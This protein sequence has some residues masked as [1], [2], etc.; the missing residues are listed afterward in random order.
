MQAF[1][2]CFNLLDFFAKI[3]SHSALTMNT[4]K[5]NKTKVVSINGRISKKYIQYNSRLRL[6]I[7]EHELKIVALAASYR[8]RLNSTKIMN[9]KTV[10]NEFVVLKGATRV[11]D[12]AHA[13][14]LIHWVWKSERFI[15]I[16][17]SHSKNSNRLNVL[18][19]QKKFISNS[20]THTPIHWYRHFLAKD[21][22]A[23]KVLTVLTPICISRQI[24][25]INSVSMCS[26]RLFS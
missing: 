15:H 13:R 17:E 3:F 21:C 14:E 24:P 5:L 19:T 22:H 18:E 11:C 23:Q 25:M 20:P 7:H 26:F 2:S 9:A 8:W 10:F 4:M 12:F 16:C 1:E 6:L